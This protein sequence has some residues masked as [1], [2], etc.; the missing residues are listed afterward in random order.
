MQSTLPLS[1]KLRIDGYL[2]V[3]MKSHWATLSPLALDAGIALTVRWRQDRKQRRTTINAKVF[4]QKDID[5]FLASVE[6]ARPGLLK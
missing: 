4:A 3:M 5:A 2:E 1:I 6:A